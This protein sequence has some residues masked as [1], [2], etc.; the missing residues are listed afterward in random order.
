MKYDLKPSTFLSI[1]V[2][3]TLA[4]IYMA[5]FYSD[6]SKPCNCIKDYNFKL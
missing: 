4:F 1:N 3:Q 5:S 6:L 2:P